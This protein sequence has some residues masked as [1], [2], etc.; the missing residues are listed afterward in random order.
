MNPQLQTALQ[1]IEPLHKKL[2]ALEQ[3]LLDIHA[4]GRYQEAQAR[5]GEL[6]GLRDALCAQLK[7]LVPVRSS[8]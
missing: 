3:S 6:H 2:H 5:L 4:Q 1:E 8:G 7:T